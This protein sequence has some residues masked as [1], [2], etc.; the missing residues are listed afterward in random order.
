MISDDDRRSLPFRYD[1][2]T[3]HLRLDAS[4]PAF[5]QDPYAT[6]RALRRETSVFFWEESAAWCLIGADAVSALL[7]DRRFGREI[8]H[9]ATREELGWPEIPDRLKPFYD[10]D[11]H[12]MLEREPPV[13]TRLRALVNRAFVSRAIERLRPRVAALANALIDGF[14]PSGAVDLLEAFATPIPVV[15]IAEMLGVPT[16]MAPQLLDWSHRMVAMYQVRRTPEIEDAAVAAA[17]DFAGFIRDYVAE[18][19]SRPGDDL[20]SVLIAAEEEGAKLS[21]DELVTSCILLLNA[22]HEATVHTIG[23]GVKAILE[24]GRDPAALFA[25]PDATEATC[26][27][28][29]RFDPPLH[30]FKRYAL[31]DVEVEGIR[32]TRGDQIGLLL[33]AANRDPARWEAPDVFDPS[34]ALRPHVSFG[35][36]IHFCIGAPL[37]RLELAVALPI[38]FEC[39]PGLRLASPARYRDAYHFHGLERLDLAWG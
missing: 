22:G 8:L 18:R 1:P 11:A 32:L 16:E 33:G 36:G 17:R 7:R 19:R 4:D 39:L 34:R 38:L 23:N 28:I 26:E 31:E 13:H 25:G 3:R 21:E 20:I 14:A 10:I 5:Y 29:L 24:S 27:E 6:F 15:V 37:A 9:V 12:S 35:G 30:L 2:A